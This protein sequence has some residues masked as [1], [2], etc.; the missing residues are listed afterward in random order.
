MTEEYSDISN[1]MHCMSVLGG[2]AQDKCGNF[3][4]IMENLEETEQHI[5]QDRKR[6]SSLQDSITSKGSE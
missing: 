4:E 3:L 1:D 5:D 6:S 2:I